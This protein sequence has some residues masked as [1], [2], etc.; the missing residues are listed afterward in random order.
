MNGEKRVSLKICLNWPVICDAGIAKPRP[1]W[2]ASICPAAAAAAAASISSGGARGEPRSTPVPSLQLPSDS[3]LMP[4]RICWQTAAAYSPIARPWITMS[5]QIGLMALI[6]TWC[7]RNRRG[8]LLFRT[9]AVIQRRQRRQ[10]HLLGRAWTCRGFMMASRHVDAAR[11]TGC[12]R[13]TPVDGRPCRNP[14]QV[15]AGRKCTG[16]SRC[17]RFRRL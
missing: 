15:G 6:D 14:E 11:M 16:C 13:G 17:S 12:C 1:R 3:S 2:P 10:R 4:S 5:Q 8:L 9:L 7:R